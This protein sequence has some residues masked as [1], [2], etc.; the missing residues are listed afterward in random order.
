MSERIAVIGA[1]TMGSG[2]AQLSAQAGHAVSLVDVS[3]DRLDQALASIRRSA[4]KLH[5]KGRLADDADAVLSRI[6]TA[7]ST[8]GALPHAD[9]VT[10]ALEAVP[11]DP[12]LKRALL[13]DLARAL[14]ADALIATNTSGLPIGELAE[15][16]PHPERVLGLHFFNPP[17][18]MR[19]V[20]VVRGPATSDAA[21]ERA[22]A[23]VRGLDRD[24]V[25]VQ[26]D[27]PGFV[28][29][30]IAMAASNEAIRLVELGV[31]TPEEVDRGVKGAFGWKMGPLETADLVGLDVV[32]HARMQIFERTGDARF[33]PPGLV[34]TLVDA[35]K[36]GRKTGSGFYHYED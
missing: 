14:P 19:V 4:T 25:R 23:F 18:L 3:T 30:R 7:A 15:G 1:G 11:E 36:L 33:K 31:A 8:A 12:D 21:F 35:G 32:Y 16:L 5:Q 20:E 27:L 29:N 34:K 2:I 24:P 9:E 6:Q 26:R 17:V 13:A 10:L 22:V 28:L